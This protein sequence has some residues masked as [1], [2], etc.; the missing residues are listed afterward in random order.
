MKD[1]LLLFRTAVMYKESPEGIDKDLIAAACKGSEEAFRKLYEKYWQDLYKIAYRRL[2]SEED[3]KDILQETFISLWKNLHH[4]S[5]NESLGGYLYTSLR[6]KIFNYYE[7]NGVRLKT[8]MNQ[9]FKP[10]ESEDIIYS[11]LSTKELQ[12]VISAILAEMPPK[13]REIYKLSKEE[14]L[15]NAEIAGLLMLAPQ[16]IKNQ[17]HEALHRIREE[18]KKSSL[19]LFL[20]LF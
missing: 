9:P 8:L 16:T 17:I 4:I 7:K 12:L 14:Q 1:V 15:T 5:V 2:P 18:L 10:A 19:H 6:N 3:V 11:S 13:M 20:F